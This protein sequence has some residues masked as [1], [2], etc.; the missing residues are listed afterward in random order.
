[1]D[2]VIKLPAYAEQTSSSLD[3]SPYMAA[4]LNDYHFDNPLHIV[5]GCIDSIT[6]HYIGQEF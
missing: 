2:A 1:M 3:S 6:K 4:F 5:C